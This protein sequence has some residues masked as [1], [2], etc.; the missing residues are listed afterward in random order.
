[1]DNLILPHK[2]LSKRQ[3]KWLAQLNIRWT[4]KPVLLFLTAVLSSV[5]GI[6]AY[7]I[8]KLIQNIR[9][10]LLKRSKNR[11]LQRGNRIAKQ[12]EVPYKNSTISV[13]IPYPNYDRISVDNLVF[14]Q[15]IKEEMLLKDSPGATSFW[16]A[17][18]SRFLNKLFI[19][20][21]LILIPKWLDKNSYLL[22]AQLS[23]LILRTYLTLL[24]TKLD[25]SIVKNL[26]GLQGKKFIRDIIYWFLLAVPASYTNSSIRYVTKRLSLSFRTNLLRYCH[27]LYMDNRLVFYKMQF[28]TNEM[29]P[30]EYQLDSKYIDQYLTDDIKQFTSTLASLFTNTGKPFMDLIFFA[31]YLRD[32]LGTAGIV[33]IFTNYFITCWFLRLKAPK[34]SKMLKKKANLEGIYYNYNLNLIYNA[35]E[36]SFFKGIP[37]ENRKI[38]S[39]FGDLQKQIFKEMVQRF[40]YGFW[41]DYILKYTWSCLGY[42]YSAIPILLAPTSKR[43]SN[44]SKNMK[45]FIVN[46]RLMLS[47]ADAGSRLMYSIKDVSKLSGYTDRIFTLLLN[48]HQVHDSGFQY[49]LDLTNGQQTSLARLP[50]LRILSSFTN[51]NHLSSQN[52]KSL[53]FINGIIQTNYDG[54]RLE[55]IP[56]IV[57]SPKGAN[58]PKL[59]ESLSF[60]IKKGNNLLI[61]GKNGCG[62]TAFMRCLAGLWPIYEGLLSKPLDSNIM[63]VPQRPYFLSAGT[64]RDQIIY[65]LS[66]E[67]SKVDDELLIGLLKDVGLEYL[68]ERFNS[69]LN[70]RPSIKNDNVTA[71][72]GT[73]RDSGNISKNSWFSL[74]SGGERQKMIIA[75]VLFHN[76]TYVVLDEPTNAISYD[77]ED[78]LFKLLKK[79]GLTIITISHRSSLEKY[80][81]YCLELVSDLNEKVVELDDEKTSEM[82]ITTHK[83]KFKNLREDSDDSDSL[84][85]EISDYRHKIRDLYK[86]HRNTDSEGSSV[87]DRNELAK[88]EIKIL[89]NELSKLEE[90]E[91][92]KLEVLNYLD[93]E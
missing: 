3:L 34:F 6:S 63:Y 86:N 27:D 85:D 25:G 53:G 81:D 92:R 15:Y 66:S 26:I 62:K 8:A 74:L 12:I 13:D 84:D 65:P 56:I 19:I 80:H 82:P 7:N 78:Y 57:P 40:H 64:L 44:S 72:N 48:L 41:E 60:T 93:N 91:K 70:F 17:I 28:N 39:I 68:F 58:G 21:K 61:I 11:P 37:L 24:V 49:G 16:K 71:S 29:L 79:R 5:A 9:N 10:Y 35:E 50:S 76:K 33:G 59:I 46:K 32:N 69:D 45:N 77:M 18:N 42:L 89:K 87:E 90:L 88:E 51:L 52:M 2:L 38:K 31:I 36:I 22:V 43:T 55:N 30:K 83:W 1:M 47:M 14:K 4:S 67:T 75:R 73:E 23:L 20:W 54:L